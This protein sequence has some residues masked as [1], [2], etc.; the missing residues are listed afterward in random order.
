MGGILIRLAAVTASLLVTTAF[1]EDAWETQQTEPVLVKT[2]ARAGTEVKEVWAEGTIKAM[3]IDIQNAL[4][5]EKRF[6]QFM[7][8]LTEARE[9]GTREPDGAKYIYS[10]IDLPV[11]SPRDFIHKCYLDKDAATDPQGAFANHWFAV[12]NKTP[13]RSN[14]VR[15]QISEGSW[16]V[17]PNPDGKSSHVVY[18][19]SAE[20][21]GSVPISAANRANAR[22]VGD[23]FANI[24]REATK[25]A[26][27]RITAAL[28]AGK[29]PDAGPRSPSTDAGPA[30]KP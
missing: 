4:M 15:L 30:A 27:E 28:I 16:L 8:Y 29:M 23:T 26:A 24:E 21:G 19:F 12:P 10:K 1:A 17:T 13:N 22:G 5:D 9:I 14:V 2:R 20:I 11:L 6:T 25:R 7:P 3:P 18:K